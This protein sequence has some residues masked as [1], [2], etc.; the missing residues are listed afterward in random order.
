MMKFSSLN[1][2]DTYNK[3]KNTPL[4]LIVIGGGITG[5][6]TARDATMRGMKVAVVEM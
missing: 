4:D 1:R 6:G 2:T 5:A 3:M